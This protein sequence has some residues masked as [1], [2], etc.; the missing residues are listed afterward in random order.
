MGA[1]FP[2]LNNASLESISLTI[3]N[4]TKRKK[5]D[6]RPVSRDRH[7]ITVELSGGS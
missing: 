7:G 6:L 3:R 1:F 5:S 4:P 2:R